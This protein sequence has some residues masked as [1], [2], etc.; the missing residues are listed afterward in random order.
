MPIYNLEVR[1]NCDNTEVLEA[2]L[3]SLAGGEL[4]E[5]EI[6]VKTNDPTVQAFLEAWGIA[7][8]RPLAITNGYVVLGEADPV[9]VQAAEESGKD[10]W[11]VGH[12]S[13]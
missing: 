8:P 2:A 5:V 12:V 9:A 3:F 4:A 10:L 1:G 13:Q 7:Q 6:C 11:E